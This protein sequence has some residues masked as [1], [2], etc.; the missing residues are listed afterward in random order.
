LAQV[1]VEMSDQLVQF[2]VIKIMN[3]KIPLC[4]E[5]VHIWTGKMWF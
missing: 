3:S 1:A 4:L 2:I 5:L